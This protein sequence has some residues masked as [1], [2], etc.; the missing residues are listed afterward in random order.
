MHFNSFNCYFFVLH[1]FFLLFFFSISSVNVWLVKNF[2]FLFYFFKFAFME[3]PWSHDLDNRYE[4]L[5]R[6]DFCFFKKYFFNI[7]F[8]S[9]F[10][11]CFPIYR[12]ILI[13]CLKSYI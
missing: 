13:S 9:V 3:S 5:A 8:A 1:C 6:V 4:G 11:F 7:I 10:F 2:T 12:D